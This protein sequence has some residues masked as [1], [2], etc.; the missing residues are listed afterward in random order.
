MSLALQ[1]CLSIPGVELQSY[2]KTFKPYYQFL[3]LTTKS[4]IRKLCELSHEQL[5]RILANVEEGLCSFEISVSMQCCSI[6]DNIVTFLVEN[7]PLPPLANGGGPGPVDAGMG[8]AGPAGFGQSGP[9]NASFGQP[10]SP[11]QEYTVGFL[12]NQPEALRK[13]LNIMF[14]LVMSGEFGS[15]WSISRP[16]LGLILLHQQEFLELKER[17][18]L[19]QLEERK[20]KLRNFFED[21][22]QNVEQNIG[23]RNKDHF[24][25]QLY[26]FAQMVKAL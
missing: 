2:A 7:K 13:M 8:V 24:T 16:L 3:D 20:E 11:E 9:S 15:T 25:R 17:L 5:A 4:H 6:V 23:V 12:S 1:M 21:L 10:Q 22:M 19:Q 18:I 14:Q 26:T